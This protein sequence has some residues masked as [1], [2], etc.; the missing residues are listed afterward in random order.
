MD[1]YRKDL[2]KQA[3]KDAARKHPVKT[4]LIVAGVAGGAI[5]TVMVIGWVLSHL[6]ILLVAGGAA[7]VVWLLRRGR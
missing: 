6:W 5:L 2:A 3:A 7:F 1:D 4:G